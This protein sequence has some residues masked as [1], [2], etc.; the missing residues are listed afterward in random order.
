MAILTGAGVVSHARL[1]AQ[2]TDPDAANQGLTPAQWL[3]LIN[4]SYYDLYE[5]LGKA[6]VQYV[7][8]SALLFPDMDGGTTTELVIASVSALLYDILSMELSPGSGSAVT[9][10]T[11]GTGEPMDRMD[12]QEI[13]WLQRKKGTTG[14]PV[15]AGWTRQEGT[16]KFLAWLYPGYVEA[17]SHRAFA[18]YAKLFPTALV[19][20]T[21]TPDLTDSES[22]DLA[23]IAAV[24]GCAN[25]G[26][27]E[28]AGQLA[29]QLPDKMSVLVRGLERYAKPRP[30]ALQGAV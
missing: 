29:G 4:E 5:L 17:T 14:V 16:G 30:E 21:E 12:P 22:Y 15:Y 27:Y 18:G 9:V 13:R 10:V 7:G 25:L 24:R 28:L 11:E 8:A 19:G 20:S 1:L 6:R 3:S 26:D 2:D 23:R